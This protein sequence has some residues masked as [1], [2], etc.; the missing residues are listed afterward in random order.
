MMA[1]GRFSCNAV[2][3]FDL[4]AMKAWVRDETTAG[5]LPA[6]RPITVEVRHPD[7][8]RD[9]SCRWCGCRENEVMTFED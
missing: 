5:R 8:E 2:T 7:R 3:V 4:F 9:G 1:D 6:R